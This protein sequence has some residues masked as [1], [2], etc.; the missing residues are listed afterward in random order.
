MYPPYTATYE[1]FV[2]TPGVITFVT[3]FIVIALVL[4]AK[5]RDDR[6]T[7]HALQN[8]EDLRPPE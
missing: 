6:D 1:S 7:V 3:A 5:R 4:W 8:N 2:P